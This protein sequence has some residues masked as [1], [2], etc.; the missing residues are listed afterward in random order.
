MGP[1]AQDFKA[2]HPASAGGD[3]TINT[4]NE[5]GVALAAIKGLYYRGPGPR[6][7]RL[8]RAVPRTKR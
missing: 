3:T 5:M 7:D 8:R 4:G 1:M 6:L 2:E